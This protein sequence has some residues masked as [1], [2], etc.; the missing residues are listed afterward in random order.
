MSDELEEVEVSRFEVI[1]HTI[2]GAG[3]DFVKY[4][5]SVKLSYQDDGRTLKVLLEDSKS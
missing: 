4:A 5:V 1:D 2:T 3:R